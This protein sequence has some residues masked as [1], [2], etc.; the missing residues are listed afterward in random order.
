MIQIAHAMPIIAALQNS[1]GVWGRFDG[2]HASSGNYDLVILAIAAIALIA[3]IAWQF[4]P[5]RR[6]REFRLNS[7]V[8]LFGELCRAHQL[9]RSQCRLLKQLA[10]A[11]G[12]TNQALLFVEPEQFDIATL[13]PRL[14]AAADEVRQLR[15]QLFD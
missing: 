12:I 13:S 14:K 8:R 10:A 11:R 2:Q 6:Q 1:S 9:D 5:H 4:V 3:A 7:S 15:H